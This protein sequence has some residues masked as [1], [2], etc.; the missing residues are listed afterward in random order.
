LLPVKGET[1]IG[2]GPVPGWRIDLPH[3]SYNTIGKEVQS[4]EVR[5]LLLR[6]IRRPDDTAVRYLVS[7]HG[8]QV[9]SPTLDKQE[10][11]SLLGVLSEYVQC[12][13]SG[14]TAEYALASFRQR[15]L[16][17]RPQTNGYLAT[18]FETFP[19]LPRDWVKEDPFPPATVSTPNFII[20]PKQFVVIDGEVAWT[21]YVPFGGPR[22][23]QEYRVDA[24]E[25]DPKLRPKFDAAEQEARQ[26]LEKRGVKKGIG[27]FHRFADEVDTILWQKYRLKRRSF[28]DLNPGIVVD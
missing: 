24:Q 11:K 21:Y 12:R 23:L 5:K 1:M 14:H 9:S 20:P 4:D 25:F 26:N 3:N 18:L 2:S 8:I 15:S 16:E 17:T 10:A 28:R 19:S 13:M 22:V 6:I 27:Y 7:E